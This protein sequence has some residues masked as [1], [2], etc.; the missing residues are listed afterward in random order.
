MKKMNAITM[1]TVAM[2]LLVSC[3]NSP[4]IN[5]NAR[6]G[7]ETAIKVNAQKLG[8]NVSDINLRIMFENDSLCIIHA[9]YLVN[10]KHN[11]MMEYVYLEYKNQIYEAYQIPSLMNDSVYMSEQEFERFKSG[12]LFERFSYN[13]YLYYKCIMLINTH[14]RQVENK[15]ADVKIPVP[16]STG[17]W[18][19]CNSTDE[20][21][22]ETKTNYLMMEGI[23]SLTTNATTS[24]MDLHLNMIVNKD[25]F[26]FK[27]FEPDGKRLIGEENRP[28][29]V[30]IKGADGTIQEFEFVWKG[31][32]NVYINDEKNADEVMNSFNDIMNKGGVVSFVMI[33]DGSLLKTYKFKLD[34]SGYKEALDY[35]K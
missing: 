4:S 6:K 1:I 26:M 9:N 17:L 24:G 27:V 22:D 18:E 23:A 20:F 12:K 28:T 15:K 33:V 5:D 31:D 21:G 35:V 2:V 19:L 34:V 16:I 3:N 8:V 7:A 11:N 13:D 29:M 32:G 10:E 30:K 25:R 14:G